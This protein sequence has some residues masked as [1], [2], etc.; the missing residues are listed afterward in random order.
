MSVV[1][2]CISH[3]SLGEPQAFRNLVLYP[4]ITEQEVKPG[5]QLLDD[6]L[7]NGSAR[8]TEVSES[9]SVPELKFTNDGDRPV[10]LL[11]GEELVG[12]KQNRI[13]NLTVMAPANKTIVIPVSCVE[14]GRWHAESTEFASADRVHF[15]RGRARKADQVSF[16]LRSSGTRH[17][18]QGEIWE[19]ISEK[20][21]RMASFSRTGAA[22]AMYDK[23]RASLDDYLHAFSAIENQAG[24]LFCING[25]VIGFDL[26]D[27]AETLASLL[28]K[29]VRSYA[30]D[31]IDAGD[32]ESGV[33]VEL[34]DKFI[35]DAA[36][37]S[38]ERFPA[39]GKGEDLRLR[40][41]NLSGGALLVD[42][43]IVHLCVFRLERVTDAP[44]RDREGRMIRASMR[45][46]GR[47]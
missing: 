40:G 12:A 26:F 15:S 33:A 19:H 29:L 1:A 13:M 6:A 27:S 14:A 24:A 34:A 4:L 7:A 11:D 9:G 43:R 17:S 20:S 18:N 8:I 45:R 3:I 2:E 30:L 39:V 5:Y 37:A 38:I 44:G 21:E 36:N 28:P 41:D 10:L 16:S 22:A 23:H 31:A 47:V 25:E 42:E 35:K 46:R 32:K